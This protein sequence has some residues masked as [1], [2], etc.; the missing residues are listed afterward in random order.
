MKTSAIFLLVFGLCALFSFN[1]VKGQGDD[2]ELKPP[3]FDP[4]LY[5]S[6]IT[7]LISEVNRDLRV[8]KV[9]LRQL[10]RAVSR[11]GSAFST[12]ANTVREFEE[13]LRKLSGDIRDQNDKMESRGRDRWGN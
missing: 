3:S 12:T 1:I 4:S 6:E 11:Y 9:T 2:S 5:A 7:K 8:S 13:T 10:E